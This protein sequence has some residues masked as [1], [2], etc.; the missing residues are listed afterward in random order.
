MKVLGKRVVDSFRFLFS[1]PLIFLIYLPITLLGLLS[2]Y[3]D[4][5]TTNNT[6]LAILYMVFML[7]FTSSIFTFL[8]LK[9]AYSDMKKHITFKQNVDLAMNKFKG[10]LL[11][12]LIMVIAIILFSSIMNILS[13]IWTSNFTIALLIVI[14]TV[15]FFAL[16]KLFLFVPSAVLKGNLGFKESWKITKT[17]RFIELAVALVGYLI[18]SS[19]LSMIPYIGYLID[20]LVF[21]PVIIILLT[22]LYLDYLKK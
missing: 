12:E 21:G 4:F 11:A 14:A 19:L 5:S 3:V 9:T 2:V 6:L 22:L 8:I 16:I 1:N 18:I 20:S 15:F 13:L 10:L 7:A 17:K